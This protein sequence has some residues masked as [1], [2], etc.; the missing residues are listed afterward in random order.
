MQSCNAN[1]RLPFN[2]FGN[3]FKDAVMSFAFGANAFGFGLEF[4]CDFDE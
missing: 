1:I 2:L 4:V 3:Q